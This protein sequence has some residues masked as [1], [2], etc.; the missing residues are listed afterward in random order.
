MRYTILSQFHSEIELYSDILFWLF[1]SFQLAST[2]PVKTDIS[3]TFV[4]THDIT[5]I[6]PSPK[7]GSFNNTDNTGN[8]SE[9]NLQLFLTPGCDAV[10]I[11]K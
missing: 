4:S 10:E 2:L 8:V 5:H 9:N 3:L 11:I 7:L 6:V 1:Q